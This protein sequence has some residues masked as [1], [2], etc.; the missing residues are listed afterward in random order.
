MP[1]TRKTCKALVTVSNARSSPE[2]QGWLRHQEDDT[3]VLHHYLLYRHYK[4]NKAQ[5]VSNVISC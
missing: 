2:R 1:Q 3:K 4:I 5:T